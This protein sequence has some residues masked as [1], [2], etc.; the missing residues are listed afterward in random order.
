MA[1]ALNNKSAKDMTALCGF[2]ATVDNSKEAN[3]GYIQRMACKIAAEAFAEA[4]RKKEFEY[5]VLDSL[6][7][8]ATWYPELDQYSD[9]VFNV[10]GKLAYEYEKEKNESLNND[11]VSKSAGLLPGL[12]SST[13]SHTPDIVKT[14][15]MAGA[16]GGSATGGLYWLLNRHSEEDE[17]KAEQVK[18]KIDYY[19]RIS[20]EIK[21]QLGKTKLPPAAIASKVQEIMENQNLF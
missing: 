4:G 14:M 19:N 20:N 18:A 7:K 15:A 5:H 1:A 8:S 11:I 17:D 10:L 2:V 16:L 3:Y 13:A 12:I 6:S 21:N 9:V